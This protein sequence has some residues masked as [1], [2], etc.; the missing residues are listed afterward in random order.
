MAFFPLMSGKTRSV[1]PPTPVAPTNSAPPVLSSTGSVA[2]PISGDTLASTTGTW[3]GQPP[4]SFTRQWKSSTN[5][6][7]T[8]GV[9]NEASTGITF[10]LSAAQAGRF[11]F[12]DVTG[13]NTQGSLT[14]RSNITGAVASG[15][16]TN[17]VAPVIVSNGNLSTPVYG[18][19]LT[20]V[21]GT[22]GGTP[23]PVLTRQ[24]KSSTDSGGL[25]GLQNEPSVAATLTLTS[26]Q[27]NRYVFCDVTGTNVNGA[28][29]VRSNISGKVAASLDPISSITLRGRLQPHTGNNVPFGMWKDAA[30]TIPA[31]VAGDAVHTYRDELGVYRIPGGYR[32]TGAGTASVNGNYWQCGPLSDGLPYYCNGAHVMFRSGANHFWFISDNTLTQFY[33]YATATFVPNP[34]SVVWAVDTYGTAPVPVPAPATPFPVYAVQANAALRP[35]LQFRSGK[36][37]LNFNG[38]Q[39]MFV[40]RVMTGT[41][42]AT[43]VIGFKP[44]LS[45]TNAVGTALWRMGIS[46]AATNIWCF[47]GNLAYDSFGT[48]NYRSLVTAIDTDQQFNVASLKN[49]TGAAACWLNGVQQ[50]TGQPATMAWHEDPTLGQDEGYFWNGDITSIFIA[51]SLLSDAD[52]I[53]LQDYATSLLPPPNTIEVITSGLRAQL[54]PTLGLYKDQA[55]LQPCTTDGDLAYTWRDEMSVYRIPNGVL[56]AGAGTAA[57]N[58]NYVATTTIDGAQ[59]YCNG[60]CQ[61]FRHPSDHYWYIQQI[62]PAVNFYASL[63]TGY[64]FPW[65]ATWQTISG[66]A[67]APA[68]TQAAP[69]PYYAHQPDPGKRPVLRFVNGKP[70]LRFDGVDDYLFA[71]HAFYGSM[72]ATAVCGM[73]PRVSPVAAKNGAG[74]WAYGTNAVGTNIWGAVGNNIYDS[75][76][77]SDYRAVVAAADLD[78]QYNVASI[79]M[80]GGLSQAWLNGTSL[81]APSTATASWNN[82]PTIGQDYGFYWDGDITSVMIAP[83]ALV[84]PD[85]VLLQNYAASFNP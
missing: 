44:V 46:P 22:W 26:A 84:D 54:I 82:S 17:S 53:T 60:P 69:F 31:T 81:W 14:V 5:A 24:W 75:F 34:E 76:A 4:P 64:S 73:R 65:S 68:V 10:D 3:A 77:T 85:R 45:P 28:L 1:P 67:P 74:L 19:V 42:A 59:A 49:G 33:Y 51:P 40:S 9:Q 78:Q 35:T 16:P 12:C 32:I 47:T 37:V 25:A 66:V 48:S 13:T 18:N 70:V 36:P 39:F 61:L 27:L 15:A 79:R 83:T 11:V 58:G 21:T 7:G 23:A 56:V 30:C 71:V 63:Q 29:T 43:G 50:W 6:G 80:S 2:A 62:S 41:E 57:A 38:A 72:V 20:N 55:C 52:R 8:T